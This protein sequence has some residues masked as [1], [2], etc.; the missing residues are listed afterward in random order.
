MCMGL[1][2]QARLPRFE[3]QPDY[4]ERFSGDRFGVLARCSA[5]EKDEL[6]PFF[7]KTVL[8]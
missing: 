2:S 5:D 4:D 8:R 3:T 7:R 6:D 1:I